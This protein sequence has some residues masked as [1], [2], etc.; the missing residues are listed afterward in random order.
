[1]AFFIIL[2]SITVVQIPGLVVR[3]LPYAN[4]LQ[5]QTRK[6]LFT[7]YTLIF[8]IQL[9]VVLLI[10][11]GD[12][13][14]VTPLTYKRL[15]FLLSTAYVAAN[16]FVIK[17]SVFKHIFIYGMQ[18]GFSLF[19]HS[20]IALMVHSCHE[21]LSLPSQIALQTLGY[22][23]LFMVLFL[24]FRRALRNSLIFDSALT[25]DYY[26]HIIWMI[27]ALAVYSDAMVTMN[28]E[29]INSFPQ[30][31]SRLMTALSLII[32]WKWIT[33]DFKSLENILHLK[34]TNQVLHMQSEAL[35][36]QSQ[37]LVDA[38]QKIKICKHDMRHELGIISSL[39]LQNKTEKA[40]ELIESMNAQMTPQVPTVYCKNI[41]INSAI[42]V[43]LARAREKNLSV[44]IQLD[45]PEKLPWSDSDLAILLANAFE[46][47]INACESRSNLSMASE[48]DIEIYARFEARQLAIVIKNQ[49]K[50]EIVL[51][52]NG[53]PTTSRPNHGIG[54]HSIVTIVNKYNGHVSC[55]HKENWFELTFLFVQ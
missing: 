54:M 24:P 38:E 42:V 23:L 7:W 49:F 33:L 53:L 8:L 14:R 48:D 45:I 35:L 36:A 10:A 28:H 31:L 44:N 1:M 11:R 3:Y 41:L 26:W 47:A 20:I 27:P 39:L 15:L 30:I 32:S 5:A 4:A 52:G 17:G 13:E 34:N 55:S 21:L 50:G 25:D 40:L 9:L 22:C 19:V 6:R 29:W 46:N 18:G 43:Y 16:V 12:V 2:M 37:I 51:G